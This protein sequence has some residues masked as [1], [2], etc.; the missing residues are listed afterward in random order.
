MFDFLDNI[1]QINLNGIINFFVLE[2]CLIKLEYWFALE[3]DLYFGDSV[4]VDLPISVG[5]LTGLEDRNILPPHTDRELYF[6]M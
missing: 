1:V 4:K 6:R 3:V 5:R 2:D